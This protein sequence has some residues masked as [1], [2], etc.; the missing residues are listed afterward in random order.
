M[1]VFATKKK[2]D[3]DREVLEMITECVDM[4]IEPEHILGQ[5]HLNK[6]GLGCDTERSF[7]RQE[8]LEKAGERHK[9]D[10]SPEILFQQTKL[11]NYIYESE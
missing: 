2:M 3:K 5:D 1:P 6:K 7:T 9:S 10:A 11:N 4:Q 8:Q